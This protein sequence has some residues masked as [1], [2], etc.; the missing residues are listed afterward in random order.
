[1][2]GLEMNAPSANVIARRCVVVSA[3]LR[4]QSGRLV[5]SRLTCEG[6]AQV[7]LV[8]P[9]IPSEAKVNR[10][11]N[12]DDLASRC[13]RSSY[14]HYLVCVTKKHD[15]AENTRVQSTAPSMIAPRWQKESPWQRNRR[16][17]R[18]PRR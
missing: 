11:A 10:C 5:S 15:V 7:A 1:M 12:N 18:R 3:S 6:S 8:R 2:P 17:P 13:Q 9:P 14:Y 4:G 16:Y